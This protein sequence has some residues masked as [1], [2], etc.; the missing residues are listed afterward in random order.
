[1]HSG[2]RWLSSCHKSTLWIAIYVAEPITGRHMHL[3]HHCSTLDSVRGQG[4]PTHLCPIR[5]TSF[6]APPPPRPCQCPLNSTVRLNPA[7]TIGL[8]FLTIWE[9]EKWSRIVRLDRVHTH[10]VTEWKR[11]SGLFVCLS[12]FDHVPGPVDNGCILFELFIIHPW[13]WCMNLQSIPINGVQQKMPS[14]PAVQAHK[15]QARKKQPK[16]CSHWRVLWF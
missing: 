9:N 16:K 8:K 4:E 1:M 12:S 6:I 15:S 3:L 14:M 10:F 2:N 5:A 13:W 11:V 7:W